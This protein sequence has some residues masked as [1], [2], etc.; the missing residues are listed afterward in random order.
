MWTRTEV[1]RPNPNSKVIWM[2]SSGEEIRGT[3][4]GGVI[5]YPENSGMYI[6]YTPVMWK[7]Q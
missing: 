1:A 4:H 5:W 6:Y 2:D 7:Y 3:Y